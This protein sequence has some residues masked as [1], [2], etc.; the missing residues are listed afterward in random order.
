M[1]VG[2]F[3]QLEFENN[4]NVMLHFRPQDYQRL[5]WLGALT[6]LFR[7]YIWNL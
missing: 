6:L 2:I 1:V 7:H 3:K 5:S 4:H